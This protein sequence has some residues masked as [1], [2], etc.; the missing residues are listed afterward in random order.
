MEKRNSLIKGLALAGTI[1]VWFPLAAPLL[2]GAALWFQRH[3]F[4][5][6]YL[7]PAELFLFA[8][9]GAALLLV[10]AW[11]AHLRRAWIASSFAAAVFFLFGGQGLA[12]WTGLASG[13]TEIGGWQWALVLAML[14]LYCLALAALGVG[15]ILLMRD[16]SRPSADP[17]Q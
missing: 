13:E 17:R 2:A 15:G 3:R 9:T 6:D 16:L 11:L 4:L 12:M 5:F 1:F 8:L 7:M 10:S 14:A